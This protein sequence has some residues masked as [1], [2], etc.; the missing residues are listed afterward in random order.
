M[1]PYWTQSPYCSIA[2][3]DYEASTSCTEAAIFKVMGST[4]NKQISAFLSG[5]A[6]SYVET[7]I[8]R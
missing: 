6:G 7:E 2:L 3:D 4:I 8:V 5:K 1:A